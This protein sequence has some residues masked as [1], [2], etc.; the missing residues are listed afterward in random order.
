[1]D[2]VIGDTTPPQAK[3]IDGSA[4]SLMDY[5]E[6]EAWRGGGKIRYIHYLQPEFIICE[7]EESFAF[8]IRIESPEIP[9]I[10]AELS[11][12]NTIARQQLRG[13]YRKDYRNALASALYSALLS[14]D[15]HP[16]AYFEPV[17]AFVNERGPVE[18]VY[19]YSSNFIVYLNN[20]N[21]IAYDYERIPTRLIPV[22]AEF[23]RLQHISNCALKDGDKEAITPILGTDLASAFGSTDTTAPS[24][25]FLSSREFIT[26]RSDAILRSEYVKSSVLSSTILL[27]AL[28]I[29]TYYLKKYSVSGWLVVLGSVGGI[30][31]ATISII[32]RGVTLT[33]NPFVPIPHVVFQGIVRVGLGGVFG[34][35]LIV[36]SK[37]NLTLGILDNNIWS[38]FI[39]SVVA[40]LSERFVPDILDRIA[41]ENATQ[42]NSE[43]GKEG[44]KSS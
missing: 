30:I 36:A 42:S 16:E 26:N 35:L 13:A 23:H 38:L 39:F 8:E 25:H 44:A 3:P 12:C 18:Y 20:R 15:G 37:A 1:M 6:G 43:K 41:T 29:I 9:R 22:V 21:I 5:K 17:R 19:G 28:A 24:L 14:L 40:G 34:A 27:I 33:V 2:D 11:K 31:G 4:K 10:L 7:T 32:Q